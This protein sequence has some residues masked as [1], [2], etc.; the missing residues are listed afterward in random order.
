[1]GSS[2]V[3]FQI[4]SK[5]QNVVKVGA[6]FIKVN[7]GTHRRGAASERTG[8]LCVPA[9]LRSKGKFLENLP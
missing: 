9:L 3:A 4:S 8:T 1:L 6:K 2:V 5:M 7:K